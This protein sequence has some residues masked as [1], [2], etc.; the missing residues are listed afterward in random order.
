[1]QTTKIKR[2]L[3]S[4]VKRWW[5]VLLLAVSFGLSI[6]A[7]NN[8]E[9]TDAIY[10]QKIYPVLAA[11]FGGI[12]SFFPFSLA[13]L[14]VCA[15]LLGVL[16]LITFGIIR[17]LK[18]K[19][20]SGI[21]GFWRLLERVVKLVC[22]LF[23]AFLLLCGMNYYRLEFSQLNGLD[24]HPSPKEELIALCEE[25]VR[26]AGELRAG[27]TMDEY[28]VTSLSK[29]AWETAGD[30]RTAVAALSEEYPTIKELPIT[31]KPVIF[32]RMMS[33]MQITGV[34]VPF[35]YEANVN[36]DA[37]DYSVPATMCHELAHTRGFMREDEANFIAYLACQNAENQEFQY[38]GAMLALVHCINRLYSVDREE[39]SRIMAG[40]SDGIKLDMA[41]SSLYWDQ[42]EG[43]VAQVS[44]AVNNIYL[45]ANNQAD[46]VQSYGRM[47][48]LLLADRRQRQKK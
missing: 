30:A 21:S 13:E 22:I 9:L 39:A 47:V 6:L 28:G 7:K 19:R 43:P 17:L 37:P 5:P 2:G 35:I 41:A 23:S 29:G 27:L 31:P 3:G 16:V 42:F 32:S 46:G 1:M 36:I 11:I 12:S 33:L 40:C 8:P 34:F 48:D 10:S 38:S 20:P 4:A 25:L 24:V 14:A 44:T 18:G 45:K 26:N 15:L